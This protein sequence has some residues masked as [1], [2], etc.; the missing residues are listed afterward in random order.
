MQHGCCQSVNPTS[1][2]RLRGALFVP[3]EPGRF[4]E[5]LKPHREHF[6]AGFYQRS[7]EAIRCYGAHAHLACCSMCGAAA[8]SI[9]LAAAIRKKGDE[10][11]V[12]RLYRSARGRHLVEN[13]VVG[14]TANP[15]KQ[16]VLALTGLLRYWRDEASHGLL[17]DISENEAYTSLALLLRCAMFVHENWE[18]LT[19]ADG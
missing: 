10:E 5:M 19:V 9:L 2:Q 3:T 1:F 17:R 15:L 13:L 16:E 18:T 6:G 8:E 11:A 14:Q 12:L 4:A 7:Q